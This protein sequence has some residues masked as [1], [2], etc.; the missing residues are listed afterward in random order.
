MFFCNPAIFEIGCCMGG[1]EVSLVLVPS[2]RIDSRVG[3]F[4]AFHRILCICRLFVVSLGNGENE[5]K[6]I[7]VQKAGVPI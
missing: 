4:F 5:E 6:K 2:I 3:R 1:L 7:L